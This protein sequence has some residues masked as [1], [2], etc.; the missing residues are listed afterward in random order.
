MIS[1]VLGVE[2]S[3][4]LAQGDFLEFSKLFFNRER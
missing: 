2:I 4:P 1:L 3:S